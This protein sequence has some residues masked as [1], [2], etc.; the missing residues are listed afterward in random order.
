MFTAL[1][2]RGDDLRHFGV[3]CMYQNLESMFEENNNNRDEYIGLYYRSVVDRNDGQLPRTF[4]RYILYMELNLSIIV[5][6]PALQITKNMKTYDEDDIMKNAS[7]I[8]NR[9]CSQAAPIS[10]YTSPICLHAIHVCLVA[11]I[12]KSLLATFTRNVNADL[13]RTH[14]PFRDD[15]IQALPVRSIYSSAFDSVFDSAAC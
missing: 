5:I 2:F 15:R 14:S 3:S 13:C 6:F 9:A 4:V 7:P 8:K 12:V 1:S 11:S 10:Y